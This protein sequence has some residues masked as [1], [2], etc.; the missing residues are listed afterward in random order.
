MTALSSMY[1]KPQ[2][3]FMGTLLGLLLAGCSASPDASNS[4]LLDGNNGNAIKLL[5]KCAA[6]SELLSLGQ[7]Q[8]AQPLAVATPSVP[9][10]SA[11]ALNGGSCAN[12]QGFLMG[13][14]VF[15]M[16]G[17]AGDSVSA[18]YEAPDH[19]LRGIHLR[20]F[21]RAFAIKSPCNGNSVVMVITETGFMTQGT[22]QT[23]MDLIKNDPELAPIYHQENVML[24][25]THTH[26]GPGGEAHHSAYN[27]FRAGYDDY[28]HQIYSDSIYQ[29]IKLAHRNL[30][31]NGVGQIQWAAQALLDTND[32][33][34]E[35]AYAR[36]P[37]QER[38]RWQDINGNEVRTD[39]QMLQIRLDRDNGA[40]I[41]LLNYFPVHTTSVGTHEPLISSDNKGLA[42]IAFEKVFNTQYPGSPAN[43]NFVAAFAQSAHGDT[44][45]NLCFRENP[46]PDVQI[47]CG[48]DTLESNAASGVKQFNS[49]LQLFNGEQQPVVGGIYSMLFHAKMDAITVTD[50]VVL[51]SLKHPPELDEEPKRTC[52]AALGYSMAAGAEDNRGPSQEG[53]S[54]ENG[55]VPAAVTSDIITGIDALAAGA[56]GAGYPTI[57]ASTGGTV[58]GCNLSN[59]PPGPDAD[60]SC[61]AEKPILFPI[62]T[63]ETTSNSDLPLQIV[64]IGNIAIVALPWEVTTI[65]GRRI[66]KMVLNELAPAGVT[67]VIV[68]S[69]SNDFVQ[70]LT[71]R[72][73][74]A[75]QQY[76]G[77]STHFGPWTL[78]A[79][80]QEIRKIAVA[81]RD[82]GATPIGV[83]APR[84]TP[85]PP[86]RAAYRAGDRPPADGFGSVITQA[87]ASYTPGDTVNV[88]FGGAHP[89][90][91]SLERRNSSYLFV[92]R[93]I[94]NGWQTVALDRDPDLL[95][96]WHANPESP[97]N[98]QNQ[99]SRQSE[100]E[101]IWNSP[102]NIPSGTY[103]IRHEGVA[104]PDAFAPNAGQ[105]TE[106]EGISAEFT[107]GEPTSD[108][109]GYPALF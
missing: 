107:M 96:R 80:Q 63:N 106:Y 30:S 39:K 91:D 102:A 75:S 33:R 82:G 108:C 95:M 87:E 6:E 60:Y 73:E 101:A 37:E 100:I 78:A 83:N 41:G 59:L 48:V 81:L 66:R 28:V 16:T 64:V 46:Y 5:S 15:D 1:N 11:L 42:A 57:P 79:A 84:T 36:N 32:N 8:D 44:S 85:A 104:V 23:V 38:A 50:P 40:S 13:S 2:A 93:Q 29:A 43:D 105:R 70:Y 31:S 26:S 69:L 14:A 61:H 98:G 9:R 99:P 90:N 52:S 86:N 74:Y 47:G 71:S 97:V 94:D 58:I 18:G 10:N 56:N 34:S 65:P 77:G 62:G 72:E 45:P 22:R 53:I 76:E 109:P 3:L 24:S 19:V 67:E 12:N 49:A 51:A 35:P 27:L 25:A 103:R 55:D 92:E 89:R 20:Q 4:Q 17:P 21:A 88:S 7:G 54:C 68:A